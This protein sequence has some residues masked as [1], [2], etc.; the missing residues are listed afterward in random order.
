MNMFNDPL[1]HGPPAGGM[2]SRR[3]SVRDSYFPATGLMLAAL[4]S[5]GLW[6]GLAGAVR[7]AT[8]LLF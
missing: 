6:V 2:D 8:N 5:L 4:T 3:W 7:W 1:H